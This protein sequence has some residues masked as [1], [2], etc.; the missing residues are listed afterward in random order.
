[1]TR[2]IAGVARGRRLAVPAT[3]TRPTSDHV[4]EAMFSTMESELAARGQSWRGVRVLDLFAGSGALGLEALSRGAASAVLVEKSRAAAKV[5]TANAAAID[6]PGAE[7]LVRDAWQVAGLP[8]PDGG[9]DL[10]FADPPYDWPAGD[11]RSLLSGLVDAGWLVPDARVVV[12][13]PAKDPAS[14]L[15][16]SWSDTRRRPYGDTA[17]WYG[18]VKVDRVKELEESP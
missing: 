12:E 13:R 4:R 8:P 6:C 17:L 1:M 11:V 3:G 18:Q 9:V 15:P 5:A 16:Q 2:I 10:C 7:V 14:P